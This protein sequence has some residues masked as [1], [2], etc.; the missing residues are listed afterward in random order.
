MR[1]SLKKTVGALLCACTLFSLFP[2]GEVRAADEWSDDVEIFYSDFESKNMYGTTG[3]LYAGTTV[4]VTVPYVPI[5]TTMDVLSKGKSYGTFKTNGVKCTKKLTEHSITASVGG[6]GGGSI[7]ASGTA[8][9][10]S[11]STT[12]S[13]VVYS[14]KTWKWDYEIES[15]IW[16]LHTYK[17]SHKISYSLKTEDVKRTVS[18]T[19][20]IKYGI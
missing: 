6:M 9:N 13:K 1:K 16:R 20:K 8:P 15:D 19:A 17:E 12:G 4:K 18:I 14:A 11:V 5:G 7:T 2:S 3:G 10:A